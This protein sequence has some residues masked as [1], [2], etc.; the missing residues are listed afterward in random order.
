MNSPVVITFAVLL[1]ASIVQSR[2]Y[3]LR[4]ELNSNGLES[5]AL[6]SKRN[7]FT[8]EESHSSQSSSSSSH[9]RKFSS[10][11]SVPNTLV[12]VGFGKNNENHI[13]V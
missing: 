7:S 9:Y 13:H 6:R 4:D 1:I 10:S 3:K 12:F 11:G 2:P 8:F 5:Q